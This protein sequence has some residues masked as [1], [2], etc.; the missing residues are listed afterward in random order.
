MCIATH[1]F[2]S[3]NLNFIYL[4]MPVDISHKAMF[5]SHDTVAKDLSSLLKA[6]FD[7]I[8]V[9]PLQQRNYSK[10]NRLLFLDILRSKDMLCHIIYV[11]QS[12]CSL[13]GASIIKLGGSIH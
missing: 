7:T 2:S 6:A 8:F 5:L 1:I 4:Y 13:A 9:C 12:N 11:L 10:C 3:I